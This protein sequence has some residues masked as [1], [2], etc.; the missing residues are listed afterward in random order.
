MS[1]AG[2]VFRDVGA[3]FVPFSGM[4]LDIIKAR[5][6]PTFGQGLARYAG[7]KRGA[8][9]KDTGFK[10]YGASKPLKGF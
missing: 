5:K 2:K 7:V 8:S 9:P 3:G 1:Q 10:G 6:E 4:G